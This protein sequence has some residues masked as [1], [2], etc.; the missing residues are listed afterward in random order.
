[1]RATITI[2]HHKVQVLRRSCRLSTTPV[3]WWS[4]KNSTMELLLIL[5][6]FSIHMASFVL[7]LFQVDARLLNSLPLDAAL[8]QTVE[9]TRG[10]C[11][12]CSRCPTSRYP[13]EPGVNIARGK[14]L[15]T[16]WSTDKAI[17]Y[18]NEM[19]KVEKGMPSPL[20]NHIEIGWIVAG[21]LNT[22][23]VGKMG[24]PLEGYQNGL[25]AHTW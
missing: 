2:Y 20:Q 25:S 4:V 24:K 23:S 18:Q 19:S 16:A 6:P 9:M 22:N 7:R 1:M 12:K 13:C 14:N 11:R 3:K 8:P 10:Q 5:S 15:Q 21:V 17:S